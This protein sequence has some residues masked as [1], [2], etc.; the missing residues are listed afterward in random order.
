MAADKPVFSG[1]D[2]KDY[3]VIVYFVYLLTE[4]FGVFNVVGKQRLSVR[5]IDSRAA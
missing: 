3:L 5:H 4:N 1:F 2:F